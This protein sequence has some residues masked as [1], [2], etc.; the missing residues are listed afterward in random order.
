MPSFEEFKIK[1]NTAYKQNNFTDAV[2]F[3][4]KAITYDP[5]NP[6]GYSNCAM[7]LIK[8]NNYADASQM[9]QRGLFY[10]NE[11]TDNDNKVRKKLQWRLNVCS[12]QLKDDLISV[13]IHEVDKLPGK[14]Q[15]L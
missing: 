15:D 7:A 8:L 1:G 2:N 11:Q 10:V 4:K 6:V 12:E 13:Q 14:Y 9:C 5:T 3:Y